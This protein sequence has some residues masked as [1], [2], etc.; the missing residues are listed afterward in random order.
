LTFCVVFIM[1]PYIY[2]SPVDFGGN[3]VLMLKSISYKLKA[4]TS[5]FEG[6][7]FDATGMDVFIT[8]SKGILNEE[9][10]IYNCGMGSNQTIVFGNFDLDME[11]EILV[12]TDEMPSKSLVI[13]PKKK[14][15]QNYYGQRFIG[16]YDYYQGKFRFKSVKS[17]PFY[18]I[19]KMWYVDDYVSLILLFGTLFVLLLTCLLYFVDLIF[20]FMMK[21]YRKQN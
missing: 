21:F 14:Y 20:R 3:K 18:M 2:F 4:T 16:I 12:I 9:Y 5:I 8:E 10:Y 19:I 17:S 7:D 1:V 6:G 13:N 11:K 15:D